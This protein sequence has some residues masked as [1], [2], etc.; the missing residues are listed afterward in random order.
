MQ[1]KQFQEYAGMSKTELLQ[2]KHSDAIKG[3]N[4]QQQR[5]CEFYITTF[6][7]KTAAIRAGYQPEY[8]TRQA[9]RLLCNS[10]I[11]R[12]IAWL[13]VRA[14]KTSLVDAKD[15]LDEYIRIAFADM[16]DF[17]D[18]YPT[19][20]VLKPSDEVDGQLVKSVRCGRDGVTVE[21]YD[22]MKAM[23][24]LSRYLNDVPK[25]WKQKIEEKK[26]KLLEKEFT[27]KEKTS[28]MKTDEKED[29]NFINALKEAAQSIWED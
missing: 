9:K 6:N 24:A 15:L 14:L 25:D 20:V 3:L 2:L 11:R 23:E 12:Y 7:P 10:D 21:L 27:L 4:E 8:G 16:T 29:D 13:K 26:L 5:F 18:I 19:R 1:A 22:K 28:G 17:V